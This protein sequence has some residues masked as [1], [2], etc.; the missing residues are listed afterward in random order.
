MVVLNHSLL[1]AD[2][3]I[4]HESG[5]RGLL[6]AYDRIVLDEAHHL[7]DAATASGAARVSTRAIKYAVGPLLPR[8]RRSG[9]LAAAERLW[10]GVVSPLAEK[11]RLALLEAIPRAGRLAEDLRHEAPAL[12][13][14]VG[15]A[16]GLRG[17]ALGLETTGRTGERGFEER[18]E[19]AEEPQ[20]EPWQEHVLQLAERLAA[21]ARAIGAVEAFLRDV[22]LPVEQ[23]QP[24][25]DLRRARLRL[26][27]S[28]ETCRAML[29]ANAD[30]CRWLESERRGTAAVLCRAAIDVGPFL[31]QVLYDAARTVVFTS[32]TLAVR[33][34]FDFMLSRVG[35]LR[36]LEEAGAEPPVTC[37]WASPFDFREQVLL[38]LPRDLPPPGAPD[39][40]RRVAELL[41]VCFR[42]SK[43]G[44]FV[45][46]TSY[47][48]LHGLADRVR[49]SL[50]GR[51]AVL[52][53]QGGGRAQ[54][55][56][57]FREDEDSVLF[58]TD[59]FWEGVSV[60]GSALRLVVIPRLP[61]GVPSEPITV[62]RHARLRAQGL[63]PFRA[64][65][66]PMAVLR[67]R[68]GFGRLIR[69]RSDYGA[70]LILDRRLH[71]RWYGRQFLSALPP[72]TRAVG[73]AQAVLQ[74]LNAFFQRWNTP[75]GAGA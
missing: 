5:G 2:L 13:E 7:E 21:T 39:H 42:I 1:L 74:R 33:G 67:L 68:Q 53:Q 62:A 12:L 8:G 45:L 47:A 61:F 17:Q 11:D 3:A 64:H 20:V 25:L 46:C 63:D 26:A 32:A 35:L 34:S 24:L 30:W 23:V 56:Q 28:A 27:R 48:Q 73:P 16:A 31:S 65:S 69:S 37:S 59:S 43:G 57:R 9:V 44:A 51:L 40:E 71:D 52:R 58:G 4:K 50:A 19:A 10:G 29:E 55:L 22:E 75:P 60:K 72:A 6:P 15:L 66:L 36:F 18:E 70:V 41:D 38:G 49:A 54:L 14:A